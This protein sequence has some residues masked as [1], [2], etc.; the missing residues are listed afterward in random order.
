MKCQHQNISLITLLNMK[1]NKGDGE[2]YFQF[3]GNMQKLWSALEKTIKDLQKKYGKRATRI[4][5]EYNWMEF[6]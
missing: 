3:L 4:I 2:D 1:K 5:D 6:H